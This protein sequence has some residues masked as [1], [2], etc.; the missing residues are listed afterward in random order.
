MLI[1]IIT[2]T[3]GLGLPITAA[4]LTAATLA[5]PVLSQLGVEAV[6]AHLFVLYF[7]AISAITP[8][9]ALASFA[10]AGIAGTDIWKTSFYAVKLGVVG[11]LV[12]FLF[13]NSP[14]LLILGTGFFD[15]AYALAAAGIGLV[16]VAIGVI[17]YFRTRVSIVERIVL[18][19]LGILLAAVE[20]IWMDLAALALLG[21]MM[22]RNLVAHKALRA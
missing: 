3:L 21:T 13:V 18:V 14:G 17:G 1:A 10:A 19:A 22:A 7:A 5:V 16:A 15:T 6:T 8:P 2:I 11:Y 4:Y 20:V 9:V 12:P